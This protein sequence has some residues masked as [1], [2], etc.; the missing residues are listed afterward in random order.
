[1]KRLC[2]VWSRQ[3]PETDTWP[4]LDDATYEVALAIL[5]HH[6]VRPP[7]VLVRL[8]RRLSLEMK[9]LHARRRPV[10][11]E[12]DRLRVEDWFGCT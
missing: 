2:W 8:R 11:T 1:M 3:R 12:A 10:L 7:G 5:L 6:A 4:E 9:Q